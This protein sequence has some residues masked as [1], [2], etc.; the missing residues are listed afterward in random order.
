MSL[1]KRVVVTG[2]GMVSPIGNNVEESWNAAKKGE[3]GIDEITQFD[4][5][6]T[7]VSLAAEVK[8]FHPEEHLEKKSLRKMDRFVQF[9]MVAADEALAQAGEFPD[10]SKV[11]TIVSSGIGGLRVIEKEQDHGREAGFKR[12]S[13]YF[14]PMAISNMAA[15]QIAIA[16]GL[17]GLST[18]VVTACASGTNAI[19]EAFLKIRDDY[20][21]AC[22]CGGTE[23]SITPLALGGFAS[24][25]ALCTGTDK[26]RA[27]IPFDKERHGFVMGEGAG[28]LVLEEYEHAKARG[29]HILGEMVGYGTNCDAY[30]I[31]APLP[32]GSGAAECMKLAI[33]DAGITPE[34]IG[35]INAHGTSTPLNDL[36]ETKAVKLVFGEETKVPI[37]S[38][39][40][41]TGH[42]LGASGAV[43]AIFCLKALEDQYLPATIHYKV[44]DEECNLD[45]IPNQGREA[46]VTYALSNSLGFGGHNATLIMKRWE[47]DGNAV[48]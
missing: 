32:D 31:T 15:G 27:S 18:C 3:C 35:Y 46:D 9:A 19:G 30:H 28:I 24:M 8:D 43:E 5:S 34:N 45:V 44:P 47:E 39:K 7:A 11:G 21:S 29:A 12:I 26:E 17:T 20:L 13:P 33:S 37:S 38:T 4:A 40:S 2:M 48:R 14:I 23:A 6:M 10:K 25:K 22:V 42:L 36:G 41:M 1:K 16:H